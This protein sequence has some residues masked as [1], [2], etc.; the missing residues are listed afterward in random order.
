MPRA[1]LLTVEDGSICNSSRIC[2]IVRL[3]LIMGLGILRKK[4]TREI[5]DNIDYA[6]GANPPAQLKHGCLDE[7]EDYSEGNLS[8]FKVML[9]LTVNARI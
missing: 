5:T 3:T 7:I 6:V 2:K 8:A 9:V 4:Q 1:S